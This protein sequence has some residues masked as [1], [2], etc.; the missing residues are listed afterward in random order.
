MRWGEK[1]IRKVVRHV[2]SIGLTQHTVPMCRSAKRMHV[3][4]SHTISISSALR[5]AEASLL[6]LLHFDSE[7]GDGFDEVVIGGVTVGTLVLMGELGEAEG[8]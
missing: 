7:A 2:E 3:F 6:L 8:Y 4:I 5:K 1:E